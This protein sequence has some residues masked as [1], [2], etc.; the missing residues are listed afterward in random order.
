[1][2]LPKRIKK[3]LFPLSLALKA[4]HEAEPQNNNKKK[5]AKHNGE[6]RA[7]MHTTAPQ[8]VS[9]SAALTR[10]PS[11]I[12]ARG[13]VTIAGAQNWHCALAEPSLSPGEALQTHTHTGTRRAAR[14]ELHGVFPLC[15]GNGMGRKEPM[16]AV[17]GLPWAGSNAPVCAAE[18]GTGNT[19][20]S[21]SQP[22]QGQHIPPWDDTA[23]PSSISEMSRSKF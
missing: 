19:L 16:G 5:D 6:Q 17:R 3:Q 22:F 21:C 12:Q 13:T 7:K 8:P 1:M 2:W 18:Q 20:N 11:G 14:K 15:G 9:V 4:I 10:H 23:V